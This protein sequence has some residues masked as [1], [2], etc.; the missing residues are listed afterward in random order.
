MAALVEGVPEFSEAR[1]HLPGA[2]GVFLILELR[3][4]REI[5]LPNP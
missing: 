1:L 3:K 5:I 2:L 4:I